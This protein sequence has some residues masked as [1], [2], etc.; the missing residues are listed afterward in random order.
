MPVHYAAVDGAQVLDLPYGG[1][2]FRMTIVL[3]STAEGIEEAVEH[4]DRETWNSWIAELRPTE[5]F[6]SLPKFT[7]EYE[8]TLNDVL[9]SLGM[10]IAFSGDSADFTKLY[11]GP[12]GNAYISKVKHKAFLDINEEG[13]EA[14]AA[15]SVG[16]SVVSL[17]PQFIV[18]RPFVFAI[19]E[20][21]SGTVLFMG[22][23]VDPNR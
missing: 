19:R 1:E 6:V 23:I 2:A 11:D 22:K 9:E 16:I 14:A 7:L 18:N 10:S 13:T 15:T 8:L 17:P 4:L 12:V 20:D 5:I 3:P 21:L